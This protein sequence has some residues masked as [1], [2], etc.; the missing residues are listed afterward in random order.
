MS[1]V[2]F[3]KKVLTSSSPGTFVFEVCFRVCLD[4]LTS[5]S[6]SLGIR[7]SCMHR[8]SL[9]TIRMVAAGLAQTFLGYIF[10]WWVRET[11]NHPVLARSMLS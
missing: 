3:L 2:V 5:G 6:L 10:A 8:E 9:K 4:S 11:G 1:S 7:Y